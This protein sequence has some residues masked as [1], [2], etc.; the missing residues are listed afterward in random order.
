METSALRKYPRLGA[1]AKVGG[2]GISFTCAHQWL[3][4]ECEP[5][6]AFLEGGFCL[7]FEGGE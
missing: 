2:T 5:G 1:K 7:P 4:L 6:K 3:Y